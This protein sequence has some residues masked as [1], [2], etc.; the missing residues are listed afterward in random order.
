MRQLE[1]GLPRHKREPGNVRLDRL[2][3]PPVD[4]NASA[5][6]IVSIVT[7]T[8]GARN[9]AYFPNMRVSIILLAGAALAL[10]GCASAR[11]APFR[12]GPEGARE[13]ARADSLRYPYTTAD[14][15][16]MSGMIHHHAQA[17]QIAGWAPS[18]GASPAVIRL[19]ER[20]INAQKDEIVLMSNWLSDRNQQVPEPN[21]AGMPMKTGGVEHIMPMPGMLT[22]EQL[23]QLDAASGP[24]FDR[25]FLTFMIQHHR[26]A[27]EMVRTLFSAT[28][29][30]QDESVFKFASDV[31]VDQSTEIRRM[32]QMLIEI[33]T[34]STERS[35]E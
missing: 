3:W 31:E 34:S 18:H 13:R 10:S 7:Q 8:R 14:I 25:L 29:A 35:Q 28:G 23:K 22:P 16:F 24:D 20:I 11:P 30:G 19:T 2:A 6:E 5:T 9:A 12:M 27:V 32:L 33:P 4:G 15:D 1:P 26:G 21:P 17:I